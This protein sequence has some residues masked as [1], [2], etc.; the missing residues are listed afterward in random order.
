MLT[1]LG[2]PET[3]RMALDRYHAATNMT[4]SIAA[5]SALVETTGPERQQALDE[6]LK[7]VRERLLKKGEG[8]GEVTREDVGAE[9]GWEERPSLDHLPSPPLDPP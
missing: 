6:F 1:S 8:R 3:T 9:R 2:L 4:D 5:L 7:K